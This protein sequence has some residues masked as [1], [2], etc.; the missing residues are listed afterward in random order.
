M[1]SLN[2]Y[3]LPQRTVRCSPSCGTPFSPLI[4][5]VTMLFSSPGHVHS[6]YPPDP[7]KSPKAWSC[8]QWLNVTH[9]REE[10]DFK[11]HEDRSPTE[12]KC[13]HS[14]AWAF[15]TFAFVFILSLL[16]IVR[17]F[18]WAIM[19]RK[20]LTIMWKIL[21]KSFISDGN[22]VFYSSRYFWKHTDYTHPQGVFNILISDL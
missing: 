14:Y 8:S 10:K 2:L 1:W 12:I 17:A 20:N 13:M 15:Y 7:M 5:P 9:I 16:P 6:H 21:L 19:I 18:L 11:H 22:Y 4:R 3:I